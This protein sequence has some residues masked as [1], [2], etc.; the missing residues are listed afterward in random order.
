M[1]VSVLPLSSYESWV[2]SGKD[3]VKKDF[4]S[5]TRE[6]NLQLGSSKSSLISLWS[7]SWVMDTPFPP[8]P[9]DILLD[10]WLASRN[11]LGNP[12]LSYVPRLGTQCPVE[13]EGRG[14]AL[15]TATN[16]VCHVLILKCFSED[17]ISYEFPWR[18]IFPVNFELFCLQFYISFL[19]LFHPVSFSCKCFSFHNGYCVGS[20]WPHV[21]KQLLDC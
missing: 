19:F 5:A 1:L 12:A 16:K 13:H 2:Q 10:Q 15:W 7:E 14:D 18:W 20:F 9:T 11:G 6:E 8:P 17:Y 4:V 3:T 21:Q